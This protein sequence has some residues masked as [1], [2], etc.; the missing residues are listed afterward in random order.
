[1]KQNK[2]HKI[3][4]GEET[5]DPKLKKDLDAVIDKGYVKRFVENGVTIYGITPLGD[6]YVEEVLM[7]KD[8]NK[9]PKLP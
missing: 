7:K 2:F 3:Y 4:P 1:M 8:K 6:R 5:M 9:L